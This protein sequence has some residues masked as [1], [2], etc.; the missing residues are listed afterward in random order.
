MNSSLSEQL[1]FRTISRARRV[2][3]EELSSMAVVILTN[4]S[5]MPNV[6]ISKLEYFGNPTSFESTVSAFV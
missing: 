1:I 6:V 2:A 4:L 5:C 3:I